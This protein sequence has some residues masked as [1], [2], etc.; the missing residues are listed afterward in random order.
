M[1]K[2]VRGDSEIITFFERKRAKQK[3]NE[4]EETIKKRAIF[5]LEDNLLIYLL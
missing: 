4:G 1:G 3:K 2:Q 5:L